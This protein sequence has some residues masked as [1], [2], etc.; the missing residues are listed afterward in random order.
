MRTSLFSVVFALPL[1]VAAGCGSGKTAA[2][3]GVP[4]AGEVRAFPPAEATL[5]EGG[6]AEID[7]AVQEA[8][9]A[10]VLVEFWTLATEPSPDLALAANTRGGIQQ[11]RGQTFGNDKV[12]W[13]G[14]RK[15]EYLAHKYEGY[16]LKVVSV[17]VDAADRKDDALKHLKLHDAKYVVNFSWKDNPNAAAERYKFLGK[18]PHQ[19]VFGRNGK[20][21]WATGEP[22]PPNQTLDDLIFH[23]LDK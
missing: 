23:E 17:N 22:L 8:K 3:P 12:A 20:I 14:M 10:V 21:V 2:P 13:R 5:V 18:A 4:A 19:V 1:V 9:N 16:F 6:V 7:R 15:A 11:V